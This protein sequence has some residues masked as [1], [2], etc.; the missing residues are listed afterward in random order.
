MT[1]NESAAPAK[2]SALLTPEETAESLGVSV[3]TL[4]IWRCHKR[5]PELRY[6]KIGRLVRYRAEDVQS[7]INQRLV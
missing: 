7:F 5:Y 6:T 1:K 3:K 4:S 2:V